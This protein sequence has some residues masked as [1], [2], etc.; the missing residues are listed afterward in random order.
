MTAM[1]DRVVGKDDRAAVWA[2][3]NQRHLVLQ[4]EAVAVRLDA[5]PADAEQPERAAALLAEDVQAAT[6]SPVALDRIA[7][8]FGLT[9]FE[10]DVL[11]AAAAP[12]LGLPSATG[13]VTFA[14]ALAALSDAHW[15]ALLPDAPLRHW[16]LVDLPP[17]SPAA[18]PGGISQLPLTVDERILHGLVGAT[19][20]DERLCG[21]ARLAADLCRLTDNQGDVADALA[22]LT[23]PGP[24]ARAV[25]LVGEDHLTR[26]Q[27]VLAAAGSHGLTCLLV[28]GGDI[29]ADAPTA[30]LYGRMLARE[31]ALGG[32]LL[33]IESAPVAG[34]PETVA[35][36]LRLAAGTSAH[37][38]PTVLAL[39]E[40]PPRADLPVLR[41]PAAGP[42]ERRTLFAH[43]LAEAGLRD[44]PAALA[45]RHPLTPAAIALGVERAARLATVPGAHPDVAA[46][47]RAAAGRPL[48]GLAEL[49]RPIARLDSLVLAEPARRALSAL[50]AQVRQ[51]SRVHGE[52]GCPEHSRGLAVTALFTGPSGTGKT[53]AAEAVAADLG[54]DV[55][56]ADLS[57]VV[58]KYIGE[59]EKNLARLF[60]AAEAGAVLL[61]DEGDALFSRRTQVRDSR[62]RY[63]NLEVSYLLQRLETYSG[64]CIVTTNVKEAIDSAFTRR[65]RFVVTFPFPD[66]AQ[67]TRL[68][69]RA[70]PPGVPVEGLDPARLS[71]VAVA[72]G[73][74]V[75]L[76]LHAA[77]L[78]AE[79]GEPVRMT[80]VREAL[81]IE[82]DKLDRPLSPHEIRGWE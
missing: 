66:A 36:V 76:A 4:A 44:D 26:R 22:A 50:L 18:R 2:R 34:A 20:L 33:L 3:D 52:W 8:L 9:R 55:I 47:C 75:Q 80:H 46:A 73:T 54:L 21:R 39:T 58:S 43:A 42:A 62:D 17:Q 16:R 67:R 49:R 19:T 28:D 45:D 74:I 65:M 53:T 77:F 14:R 5:R 41:L 57:Q 15:S 1:A 37:G 24:T 72:G 56:C 64:I 23:A 6:G 32:R 27:A 79:A 60:D 35:A 40:P 7:L 25:V 61:F 12:D 78:A 48:H 31:A 69:E 13:P 51:R 63:A 30:D 70:F 38:V 11:V 82:C 81:Q 29:P 10:R 59:T 71:Q 68:W